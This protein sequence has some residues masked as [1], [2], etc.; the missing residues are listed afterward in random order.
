MDYVKSILEGRIQSYSEG[1]NI[2]EGLI[3]PEMK[4]IILP[5]GS[6]KRLDMIHFENWK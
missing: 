1:R 5:P 4:I 6:N 3:W 2:S